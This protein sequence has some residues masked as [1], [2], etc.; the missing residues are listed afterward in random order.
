MASLPR[1]IALTITQPDSP[2]P[3]LQD[4]LAQEPCTRTSAELSAILELL[5]KVPLFAE[6]A[7]G[8]QD[9]IATHAI[10]QV[11]SDGVEIPR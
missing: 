9:C 7:A 11:L 2:H 10:L 4:A 1:L 6:L 8:A 3:P 5:Q